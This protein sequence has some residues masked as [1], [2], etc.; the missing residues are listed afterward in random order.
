MSQDIYAPPEADVSVAE[1]EGELFYVVSKR[2]FIL[3]SLLTQNIYLLYW[4]Y[5]NWSLYSKKRDDAMWPV[6]RALFS[7]FFTHS[8]FNAVNDELKEQDQPYDWSPRNWASAFVLLVIVQNILGRAPEDPATV[9]AT[10]VAGLVITPLV[11]FVMFQ[12]QKAINIACGDAEGKSNTRFT[13]ANWV[14]AVVGLLFWIATIFGLYV[15]AN[16][17]QFV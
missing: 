8:L 12:G 4:F 2:K 15:I 9:V 14:W 10:T 11:V 3:L 7:I 13:W 5:Q 17:D 16:P 1:T 6:A